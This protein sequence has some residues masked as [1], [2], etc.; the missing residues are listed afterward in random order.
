MLKVV[1]LNGEEKYN[2]QTI[3]QREKERKKK[4]TASK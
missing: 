1:P 4:Q 3:E 2:E